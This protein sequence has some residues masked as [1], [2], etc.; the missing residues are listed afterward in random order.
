MAS[1]GGRS[2]RSSQQREAE[3]YLSR[4]K[5]R[6]IFQVR[7]FTCRILAYQPATYTYYCMY[8]ASCATL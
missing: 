6:E 1:S 3:D 8:I 2:G 4:I 7:V 5:L